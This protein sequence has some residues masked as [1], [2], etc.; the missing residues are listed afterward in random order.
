MKIDKLFPIN[1]STHY[2]DLKGLIIT[3]VCYFI[4]IFILSGVFIALLSFT[5]WYKNF[6]VQVGGVILIRTYVLIG[7]ITA[8][9][10]YFRKDGSAE[11]YGNGLNIFTENNVQN[12]AKNSKGQRNVKCPSCG[13]LNFE[14]DTFCLKCGT[15]LTSPNKCK[16]CNSV[17][18]DNEQFCANCG[19]KVV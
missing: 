2:K 5:D 12:A 16:N 4:L 7:I 15:G 19:T 9:I 13:A 3:I 6:I 14:T 8:I 17:I 18:H 1:K 10:K 11:F